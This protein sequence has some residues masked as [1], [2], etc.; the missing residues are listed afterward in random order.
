MATYPFDITNV[1]L[2][3]R[4]ILR[5]ITPLDVTSLNNE[6]KTHLSLIGDCQLKISQFNRTISALRKQIK[7]CHKKLNNPIIEE[8]LEVVRR[9]N[10]STGQVD[11]I[12]GGKIVGREEHKAGRPHRVI[13]NNKDLSEKKSKS[14]GRAKKQSKNTKSIS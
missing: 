1:S 5:D 11:Y 4:V 8:E 12:Y 10:P 9:T 7:E 3:S 14:K 13:T 2:V 6:I